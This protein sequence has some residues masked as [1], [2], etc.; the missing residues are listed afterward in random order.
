MTQVL[1]QSQTQSHESGAQIGIKLDG[2]NY[3]LWSQIV[4]M[5]ILGKDKLGYIYGDILQ[6]Q[7]T[8]PN[9]RKWRTENAVVK[10]WLINS[11]DPSL[12]NNFIRFLIAKEVW[13]NIATTYLDGT[14]TSH[15]Y[16]LKRQVMRSSNKEEAYAHVRREDLRHAVMMTKGDTTT[17]IVML[18]RGGQKSQQQ[19]PLQ[20]ILTK[21]IIGRCTK[22]EGL[23][24]MDDFSLGRE[25]NTQFSAK[26]H[27]LRSDNGGE[28]VSNEFQEYFNAHGLYHE[29]TCSQTAHHGVAERKNIHILETARALLTAAH[30][31]SEEQNWKKWPGFED[32]S[33]M[34][35]NEANEAPIVKGLAGNHFVKPIV[36]PFGPAMGISTSGI[37]ESPVGP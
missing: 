21:E 11:M 32:V 22:M 35:N 16:D 5:Y 2:T 34:G 23:Y 17:G 31:L 6:P 20:D 18:S 19:A 15:V 37:R 29:T 27:I 25:N 26:V 10:E 7:V 28:Y 24:Y 13:D 9:F 3:G 36:N 8:D 1:N 30:I 4:E 33:V 12:I 14:D